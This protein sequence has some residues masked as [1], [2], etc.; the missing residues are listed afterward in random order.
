M[1]PISSG[2]L[3]ERI[4]SKLYMLRHSRKEKIDSVS[5][6]IGVSKSVISQVENGRY[7][8]LTVVLLSRFATYYNTSLADIF[9]NE[10]A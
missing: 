9:H 5:K 7:R 1:H 8:S 6:G 4:G 3:F 10:Q 2:I